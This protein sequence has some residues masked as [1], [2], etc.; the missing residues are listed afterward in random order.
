MRLLILLLLLIISP[1]LSLS[2]A[3]QGFN[4][5]AI[6]RDA[7]GNVRA[8]EGVQFQFRI[9]DLAGNAIYTENH[10]V[11]TNKYGLADGIIIGKGSTV[12]DFTSV[13]WGNG[14]Y[15][16]NVKVDG[17]DL[18]TSQLLSVPYALYAL[19]AG[20]GSSGADGVGIQSTVDNGD[21]TFTLNYTD[22]TSFTTID[23]SGEPGQDG[24][25]GKSAYQS[26]LDAGNVG[27]E[28]T[29][30][31][32]L[33]GERGERGEEGEKGE[34][35]DDAEIT[36]GASSV[37]TADLDTSRVL[38]SNIAGKISVSGIATRELN[39]LDNA[40]SNLQNQIDDKQKLNS[41]LTYISTI[42][43][44]DG[45]IIVGNG[46]RFVGESGLTARTSLGLGTMSTQ[47]A[48][49][50]LISGGTVVGIA[51]IAINDGG[52]GASTADQARINLNVDKAG[53]DN[54]TNV[55]LTT[56]PSNYLTIS[57][58]E[59]TSGI[60]PIALGGTGATTATS[61]RA[62]LGLG[63]IATQNSDNISITGG[64]ITG[65]TDIAIAD[66]GTGAST[67][68]GARNNLGLG[69]IATQGS[70]NV[71]ITGG[72]ITGITDIA[73]ADGGTGASTATGARTNL[74]L[75]IGSDIQAYDSNL[76]D[77][78]E[79]SVAD[80]NIIVGNG[81]KFVAESGSTARNSLG[82]GS[83]AVQESSNVVI[84]GG[85][86]TGI[87]DVAVAD[88]GTGASTTSDARTNLG[89]EIGSDV[90]AYDTELKAIA[91]LTSMANKGIQFTGAGSAGTFDLTNAAK[92]LI[93]DESVSAM[94]TTLRVD[95]AGTDNSTNVTLAT[96]TDN[97]LSLSGQEVTAGTVPVSLGGT[98]ATTAAAARTALG[99]DQAGTDNSTDV[100]L[101]NTNYLSISGQE[102]T[103]GTVP[104]SSGGTG[105]TTAAAARTALGVD[106]AGTDNS[107]AV[108]LAN[109]N[110]LSISGQEITG[111]TV[112]LSS[113]GTGATTAAGALSNLGVTSTASELNILDGVTATAA[114]LNI[115]D[116]VTAT[117]TELNL[118]DGVTATT[119]E[120]NYVDGV[121]SN[122]QTQ[123]DAKQATITG[124][125]TSI[126]TETLTASRAM[127]TNTDGKVDISDV[128]VTELGYLDG[129]T[130]NIQAQI[131]AKGVTI[132]GSATTIDT[133]TLTSTRAMVTDANGKVA[134][135]DVTS[136][137][138][139]ILDGVT[140]TTAEIN[141][142]DGVTSTAA[143]LN[144]LDGVTATTSEINYVDGVTSNIQTQLD[145]K[146]S[147]IGDGDLT[148]ART[149][150]LQAALDAKQASITGSATTIDTET[151]T[152]TRA[153]VTDANGKVAVSDVTSTELAILDGVTAS[154]AELNILDGVTS[155]AAELNIL[156]GV[157]A[158][159][160]ELN[161]IDGVTA[162][163]AEINY[164]D[165]V[166]SNIQTQID[167][168]GGASSLNGLSDVLAENQSFFIGNVPGSTSGAYYSV[169]L[170]TN[171]LNSVTTA[172]YNTAIGQESLENLTTG[173]RNTAIGAQSLRYVTGTQNTGLGAYAGDAITTGSNNVI[174]G[175]SADPSGSGA[176][177]QIVIG[178]G[179][180]GQGDNYAV[181]GNADV[182]RVYAAQD[183][184]ATIYAG[185][186]N[187]GGTA[188][189][190]NANELNIL[191]GV[192]ATASEL[193]ILNGVTSAYSELNLVD[194]SS[195]G[196]IVNSKGVIYGSSGEVNATTLQIAGTSI[197]S[198]AAELNI[199]D[200]VTSTAAEIN[201]VDGGTSATS[202]T[203]ADAD[204]VVLNDNGTMVQVAVTDLK[205]YVH[206]NTSINDLTDGK[207]NATNFSNS[208]L[209]GQSTTGTLNS[210]EYNVGLGYGVFDALTSGD[211]NMGV[212]YNA[213]NRLTSGS[214]NVGIGGQSLTAVTTGD[215]NVAIGRQSGRNVDDAE[216]SGG[217]DLTTGD[218]NTYLGSWTQPSGAAVQNETV[219]GSESTGQ[220]SNTVTIGNASVT[221]VYLSQ[222]KGATVYA[223]ALDVTAAA[224][225][226]LQNDETITN[227]TDGTV[228]IGGNL[229]G[230]GSI[231]GFDANLNDQTGTTYTL[232]SSDNGK[233]VTLNNANAI[234]LTIA[235]SLG[236]GF[237]CLIVQKGSGQVTLSAATGVT[238]ANRSS[239]TKTA[240][241]YATVS[242]IN[243]G[244]DTYILSGD[245]GS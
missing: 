128:T 216:L 47:N 40:K 214:G 236:D 109:T 8:N 111:G 231:S 198:T 196:T 17:V 210:A 37:V 83:I 151:L 85:K 14:T 184:G 155:T 179:A 60:V 134:V 166:T 183:A 230:T 194:G 136:T 97:Y 9:Q 18:G 7:S 68:T 104:L 39:Y 79:L 116:G 35:G 95:Q 42:T 26:W 218:E 113:G 57:G 24:L 49:S 225:I 41:N 171:S 233:V 80:G 56:V 215:R 187:I 123:L 227:S 58:Q 169:G 23:F 70:D 34:K 238:I 100:T 222:D 118:I 126:D 135:S 176:S 61:A 193:N 143:E 150:G 6:V 64:A 173:H 91:G 224:G 105:A 148:I 144:V 63:S 139:A 159:A 25:P 201:I 96:V 1:F 120:I 167:N 84:T 237:N 67:A 94:R 93:D 22:G 191:D 160:T 157:T 21:G 141:I 32:S 53:T 204:R 131:D 28:A 192:I 15:Y 74:G 106:A 138:L 13:D 164:L 130:S 73:I 121:T 208:I 172:D 2:Q 98:G 43:P 152:S 5:Q 190:S 133:E 117:A 92:T 180:T 102:I 52:T 158:T 200:G 188:V 3:P 228:E 162:T 174:V 115:L 145:A 99:V 45:N 48:N 29:F 50:V 232:T 186:L 189:T 245:T 77:I 75:A 182:T 114:E 153:M 242:V 240:G 44:I 199:L 241:Q 71:T 112:P 12:D 4:Y 86:I 156:D 33:V 195:A 59:I 81:T 36:G 170:G 146:Q 108:T 101:A 137:E 175:Y 213:L 69:S 76:D 65:I 20:S 122:I 129:V 78:S 149:N 168:A 163:T 31:Q 132:T 140:A 54:S 202:T 165:G 55:T 220:G 51:D 11:V 82:L 142:L 205:S 219:I 239:E 185:G 38:V 178:K 72:E 46:T 207:A 209:I 10:T 89:L 217:V 19:N 177:N 243:I 88:G 235:A 147:T 103:G 154:T 221:E 107:T 181:I 16:I 110:Y 87:T 197:T 244:S 27:D 234:T 66:G 212:G 90:Q 206:T 124:S 161:L 226:T 203:V 211:R 30:L 125:A 119:A 127:V 229:S 62:T 223:G